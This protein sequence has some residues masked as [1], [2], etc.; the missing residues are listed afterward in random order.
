MSE[1]VRIELKPLGKTLEV[2]RGT[3]LQDILFLYGVEFPCGGQG[4]CRG[5]RVRVLEGSLPV[6]PEQERM[7]TAE[8]LAGG[9]RLACRS[10]ATAN[11]TLEIAQ[12]EAAILADHTAFEFTPRDGLGIAVDLGTTTLVAQ[13]LDMRSGHVLGVRTALNP[14]VAWGSDV[15][16][17]VQMGLE[18]AGLEKLRD[19]IRKAIGVLVAKLLGSAKTAPGELR[20]IAIA[21]NTVMHHLFCGIDP[22][23][24]S[25]YPFD[26]RRDGLELFTPSEVGWNIEGEPLVRFL[27]CLGG[28]VGSDLLAGVLATGMLESDN[29]VGLVDLGTNG[30]IVF[31]NRRRILC[32]STAAGPAFEGG[33][34][35][36]GMRAATGAIT[37]VSLADGRLCCRVLG[38]GTPRGICGSGLV[39]AVAAGLEM[40]AIGASGRLANGARTLPVCDPVSLTQADIRE[41][42]LAK[43]AI[44]AGVRIVLRAWGAEPEEVSALY[45]AGAFGNYVNRASARRIGLIDFPDGV[46]QPAGNTALLGAKLALFTPGDFT[47]I[48]EKTEHI[49]L[50]ADPAFQDTYVEEMVFP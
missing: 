20:E 7:L 39:D 33:R 3:P 38:H 14:Q 1:L 22:E 32:A 13:L 2:K 27:P 11:L 41:L 30:E 35:S 31:G 45:L 46:L 5:C 50:A 44:A 25:H 9:W 26:P 19:V 8:E 48:R 18:P 43:A 29:L 36:M 49:S 23:P 16:S 4:R 15:M 21:G 47:S 42:Q 37:G 40:G 12:W 34:I 17:R 6:T 24:L 10:N 28:F